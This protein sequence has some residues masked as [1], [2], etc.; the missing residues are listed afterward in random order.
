MTELQIILAL[1]NLDSLTK[2]NSQL[3]QTAQ[4]TTKAGEAANKANAGFAKFS[5][6]LKATGENLKQVGQ[7]LTVKVSAPIIAL[8]GLVAKLAIDFESSFTGVR[9]TVNATEA[10]F[11]LLSKEIRQLAKEI[12]LSVNELNALGEAAGQLGIE[13]DNIISFIDVVA[14]LGV[15]TNLSAEEAA[16]AFARIANITGLAQDQ[17][18]NL[19]SALVALGNNLATTEA[20]IVNMT[21]RMAG[22]ASQAGVTEAD[23]LALAGAFSSVGIRAELGGTAISKVIIQIQTAVETTNEELTVFAR[24]AG[25]SI[26]EFSSAFRDNAGGAIKDFIIGLGRIKK[27]GGSLIQ[28]LAEINITDVQLRNTLLS[29]AGAADTLTK[30]FNVSNKAFIENLALTKEAELRF[31]TTASQLI[32][33]KNAFQDIGITLGESLLPEIRRV[34]EQIITQ[35][36]PALEGWAKAFNDLNPETRQIIILLLVMAAAIPPLLAVLGILILTIGAVSAPIALGVIA[37]GAWTIA[38]AQI[39]DNWV[40]LEV[41]MQSFIDFLKNTFNAVIDKTR[42]ILEK[43]L[44]VFNEFFKISRIPLPPLPPDPT[45]G[46]GALLSGDIPKVT[47]EIKEQVQTVTGLTDAFTFMNEELAKFIKGQAGGGTPDTGDKDAEEATKNLND[48]LEQQI[49]VL[50]R[51]IAIYGLAERAILEYDV[52]QI[53]AAGGSKE[54]AEEVLKLDAELRKLKETTEAMG[55][56]FLALE[57]EFIP[58]FKEAEEAAIET[59]GAIDTFIG[60]VASN[61]NTAIADALFEAT[62]NFKNF[63]DIVTA[64][65]DGLKRSVFQ[66]IA[67]LVSKPFLDALNN[68][69]GRPTTGVGVGSLLSGLPGIGGLFGGGGGLGGIA[70]GVQTLEQQFVSSQASLFGQV[71][72]LFGILGSGLAGAGIGS[73]VGGGSTGGTIGGALGGIGGAFAGAA[74]S[75]TAIGAALG[76][77]IPVPILGTI[78]GAVIGGLLGSVI[79]DLFGGGSPFARINIGEVEDRIATVGDFL[80][81]AEDATSEFAQDLIRIKASQLGAGGADA[82]REILLE[83]TTELI[84]G[85]QKTINQ[86]PADIAEQLNEAFLSTELIDVDPNQPR[87]AGINFNGE[88]A[89]KRLEK[90]LAGDF[91]EFQ[92]EMVGTFLNFFEETAVILGVL[93]EAAEKIFD[94]FLER[95]REVSGDTEATQ[96]LGL[97]VLQQFQLFVDVFNILEGNMNDVFQTVISNIQRLSEELGLIDDSG[98]QVIP[99][100]QQVDDALRE[101]FVTGELTA[102]LAADFIAL[103]SA[104]ISLRLELTA[105]IGSL[106]AFIDT[107]NA[108]IVNLGGTAFDTSGA[109]GLSIDALKDLATNEAL[110]LEEREA[111]LT[112]LN[113]QIDQLAAQRLAAQQAEAQLQANSLRARADAINSQISALQSQKTLEQDIARDKIDALNEELRIVQ[114]LEGLVDSIQQNILDLTLSSQSP[115]TVFE[116]LDIA[117]TEIARLF[118]E[119]ATAT[120]I[121]KIGIGQEIQD[122]LNTLNKLGGEAFQQPSLEFRDTFREVINQLEALQALVEPARSVEE[123][124]AS[125][126]QIEQESQA[127]LDS[128]DAQIESLRSQQAS[129]QNQA[130]AILAQANTLTAAGNADLLELKEFI[131]D[132]AIKILELRLE[133]LALLGKEAITTEL[134]GLQAI[135]DISEEQLTVLRAIEVGITGVPSLQGGTNGFLTQPTLAQLHPNEGVFTRSQITNLTNQSGDNTFIFNIGS[136]DSDSR[137]EQI[138]DVVRDVVK[139]EMPFDTQF[140]RDAKRRARMI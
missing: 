87:F 121:E 131:R 100:L 106:V 63:A 1:K 123:I 69:F 89:A 133:Q 110:T 48:A 62:N 137:V 22:A 94:D 6:T 29:A 139:N 93:P 81:A 44:K 90:L 136:V 132:E 43:T 71:G 13:T 103:R 73:L 74:L 75:S 8:T 38:V 108:Q 82:I 21:L 17:F 115:F 41:I 119:L 76:T 61:I 36:I 105:A 55:S 2:L 45:G 58:T 30:A 31:A 9:K 128:I 11:A 66:F 140:K 53:V 64:L 37:I 18:S 52:A 54:F 19:G 59:F 20:E 130:N 46:L 72:G 107:L 24:I 68:L 25:Q 99:T 16:T 32:L 5:Q 65:F 84:E 129:L 28:T 4:Q 127:I 109:L 70:G 98:S 57:Q 86:L 40:A 122:L 126:E 12:P 10:E 85:I 118:E 77:L 14:K 83:Q 23:I 125:I 47:R 138:K 33:L 42:E 92:G 134:E 116:R 15:T 39:A 26:D 95:F 56:V 114:Q 60:N 96:A 80:T 79:G 112:Q 120:D 78:L 104:I 124:N 91:S 3:S 49:A 135:V 88:E 67:T 102:E 111:A 27:E 117:R 50:E 101:L 7:Q 35:I 97:E 34:V 51:S 113:N